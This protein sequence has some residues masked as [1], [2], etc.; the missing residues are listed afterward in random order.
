MFPVF[1]WLELAW[2]VSHRV[3]EVLLLRSSSSSD[4]TRF[5]EIPPPPGD[6]GLHDLRSREEKERQGEDWGKQG[7]EVRGEST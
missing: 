1:D 6:T 2:S 3:Y 4:V 5:W 7:P